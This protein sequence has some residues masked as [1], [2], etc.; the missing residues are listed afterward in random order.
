V[1][2]TDS[3]I[4]SHFA[5]VQRSSATTAQ[6][7]ILRSPGGFQLSCLTAADGQSQSQ[8]WRFTSLYDLLFLACAQGSLKS[9]PTPRIGS[10][11]LPPHEIH[12]LSD[13]E[14]SHHNCQVIK[15]RKILV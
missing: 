13:L 2:V 15:K 14:D 8:L 6:A 7:I 1:K 5:G 3:F 11:S 4:G 9:I 10:Q 12:V